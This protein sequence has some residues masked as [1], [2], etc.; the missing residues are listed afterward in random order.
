M[1]LHGMVSTATELCPDCFVITKR[2]TDQVVSA[3]TIPL[4]DMVT[5]DVDGSAC[6]G[7]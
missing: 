3:F 6:R 4:I 2:F 1:P 7:Q 5:V